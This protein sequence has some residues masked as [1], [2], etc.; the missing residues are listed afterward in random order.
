MTAA[1]R[2]R[3]VEQALADIEAAKQDVDQDVAECLDLIGNLVRKSGDPDAVF[4]W[5]IPTLG[6]RW[7][8]KS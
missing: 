7:K 8:G 6:E 5:L 1:T 4:D 3:K 2:A